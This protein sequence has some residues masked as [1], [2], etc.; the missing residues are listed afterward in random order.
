MIRA[1]ALVL[2][3]ACASLSI[4]QERESGW[5]R[6]FDAMIGQGVREN[7]VPGGALGIVLDRKLAYARGV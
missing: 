7:H 5:Q 4:A 6:R 1:I 2:L 3:S